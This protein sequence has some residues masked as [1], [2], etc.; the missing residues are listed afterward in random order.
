MRIPI[1]WYRQY[2]VYSECPM[3]H[4]SRA[5]TTNETATRRVTNVTRSWARS[6]TRIMDNRATFFPSW[7]RESVPPAGA[8]C[9]RLAIVSR[10]AKQVRFCDWSIR[11]EPCPPPI[12]S[13][14]LTIKE[15]HYV[16]RQQLKPSGRFH[17]LAC[18]QFRDFFYEKRSVYLSFSFSPMSLWTSMHLPRFSR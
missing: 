5:R 11:L 9:R 6:R 10:R 3:C 1:T 7:S 2:P 14:D 17:L 18:F 15:L 8:A 13:I 4:D 16:P 12:L